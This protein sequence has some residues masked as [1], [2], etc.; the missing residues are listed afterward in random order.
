ML[1]AISYLEGGSGVDE[2]G[3][4]ARGLLPAARRGEED[5]QQRDLVIR[6]AHSQIFFPA[7]VGEA[8]RRRMLCLPPHPQP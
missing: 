3:L 2:P 5:E 6:E 1:T 8:G 7:A 4:P